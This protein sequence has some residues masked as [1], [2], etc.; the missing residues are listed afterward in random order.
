[1][2]SHKCRVVKNGYN[3][4]GCEILFFCLDVVLQA[5][6]GAWNAL[7]FHGVL[8]LVGDVAEEVDAGEMLE[9]VD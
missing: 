2:L 9:V 8:D 5:V 7:F 6:P 1:M 4:C 3:V